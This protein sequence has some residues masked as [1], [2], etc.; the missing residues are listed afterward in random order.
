[1]SGIVGGIN[2]KSSGLINNSSATDGQVYTGTGAGLPMGF[3]AAGGG[4]KCLKMGFNYTTSNTVPFTSTSGHTATIFTV[5][6]APT[7]ADSKIVIF[8][9]FTWIKKNATATSTISFKMYSSVDGYIGTIGDSLPYGTSL[10]W[11]AS[12]TRYH[13]YDLSW[14]MVDDKGTSNAS[15]VYTVHAQ[16][17]GGDYALGLDSNQNTMMCMEVAN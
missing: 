16:T 1:M 17:A 13:Y 11:N 9:S 15:R 3:E 8:T 6:F 2:L 12:G 7:A 14:C 10:T 5:T 4:G